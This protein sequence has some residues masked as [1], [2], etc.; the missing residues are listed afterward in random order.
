MEEEEDLQI[1]D[2]K[3]AG[4][5][6]GSQIHSQ[7]PTHLPDVLVFHKASSLS[8]PRFHPHLSLSLF[9]IAD[10]VCVCQALGRPNPLAVY[11]ASETAEAIHARRLRGEKQKVMR[12]LR[13]IWIPG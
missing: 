8:S 9:F 11:Y 12:D 1:P 3:A 7:C 10:D 2:D 4:A 6:I 5:C 13:V